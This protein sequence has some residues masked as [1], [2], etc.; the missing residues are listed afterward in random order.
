ML[1]A[2]T[3][4]DS[5]MRMRRLGFLPEITCTSPS[6]LKQYGRPESIDELADHFMVGFVSSRTGDIMPLEFQRDGKIEMRKISARV[7]TDNLDTAVDL[8]LHGLV[9]IQA[10]H[11]RFELL[12]ASG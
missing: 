3:L 12:L 7:M 4:D 9:L 8:A 2:G 6:Y 10:P 1:R 11:Y 5:S